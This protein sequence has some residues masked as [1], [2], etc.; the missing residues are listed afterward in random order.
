MSMNWKEIDLVLEELELDGSFIQNI[1]QPNFDSLALYLYKEGRAQTLFVSFA[2]GSCRIHETRRKIPKNPK[3]LRF[4][5]LL[6]KRILGFKIVSAKQL[7]EERVIQIV[8]QKN[9]DKS[10]DRANERSNKTANIKTT[11]ELETKDSER[12]FLFFRLWSGSANCILTDENLLIIDAFYRR[13]NK[14]EITAA[15]FSLPEIAVGKTDKKYE[16]R[17]FSE[18]KNYEKH[19]NNEAE[20]IN[21]KEVFFDLEKM[22]LSEKFEKW[23]E[24]FSDRVSLD[25]LLEKAEKQ[26]LAN[27]KKILNLLKTIDAKKKEFL[28]RE[29]L[30]IKGDLILSHAHEIKK[31]Q[32]KLSCFDF[33]NNIDIEITL[34]SKKN[35]QENAAEYYRQYKKAESGYEALLFEEKAI[36]EKRIA[37]I[38]ERDE[39]L[40]EKNPHRLEQLVRKIETPKQKLEKE[41]PGLWFSLDEWTLFVGRNAKENDDLLRHYARGLDTWFHTRDVQGGFVF[42]KNRP[43]KTIPLPILIAAGNLAVHFSKA[44]EEARADLY[45]TQVKHLKRAQGGKKSEKSSLKGKVLPQNEK[46]LHIILDKEILRKL[47]VN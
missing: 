32:K 47:G 45:Y 1:I 25:S 33:V 8:L 31:E 10:N 28:N 6:K 7:G 30:K 36:G 26:F 27:E 19:N 20:N 9:N 44:R 4:M 40:K 17:D 46:N 38:A 5:E 3:P 16:L 22:S 13:P 43:G 42:I 23:Y 41:K 12:L 34:D 11:T 37:L 35:S 29:S 39:I 18:L 21:E 14:N 24:L 15:V 2:S